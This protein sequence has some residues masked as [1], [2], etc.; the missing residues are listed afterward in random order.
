MEQILMAALA[1]GDFAAIRSLRRAAYEP[2]HP[3]RLG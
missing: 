3:R 2:D 1:S